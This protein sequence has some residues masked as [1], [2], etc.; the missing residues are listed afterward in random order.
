MAQV[1]RAFYW[2]APFVVRGNGQGGLQEIVRKPAL[3]E[4]TKSG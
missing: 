1:P 2:F 3:R 4:N